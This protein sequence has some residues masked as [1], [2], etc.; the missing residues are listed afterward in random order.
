MLAIETSCDETA[1]ALAE[2]D[3]SSVI[4][5]DNE[6]SLKDSSAL[7]QNDS[8][9]KILAEKVAS[10][11]KVHRPYGGVVPNLAKREHLKN[12]PILLASLSDQLSVTSDQL[13]N[14]VDLIAVTV[15]P[16]LEPAL[17]TGINF[18]N[19]LGKELNVPVVGINH[20]EGHIFSNWLSPLRH[21]ERTP[22]SI[23]GKS[24]NLSNEISRH[25]SDSATQARNNDGKIE[26]P[27][28]V[29]LVSGGHT[30][31]LKMDSI[32]KWKKLGETRD[33]A[34]GE[35]FDKVAK[36][37]GL[38]YPG[39][40]EIEKLATSFIGCRTS[41]KRELIDFPRPM[42]H[43][44]NYDFSFSGLKTAVLYYLRNHNFLKSD[45][46]IL[47]NPTSLRSRISDRRRR[48]PALQDSKSDFIANICASFQQAAIDVLVKKTMRAVEEFDAKSVLL[49]GGVAANKALQEGLGF[50]VQGLG[51]QFFVPELKY[52]TDNAV[53]IA[54]A[55]CLGNH[56]PTEKALPNLSL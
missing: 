31:L 21:S 2:C 46:L 34:V 14:V 53:M 42:L 40:P 37:L 18:A 55:A 41:Y 52:N 16:G 15:G 22:D 1:L 36:M 39:G 44:K 6:G 5:S 30:I 35:A 50:G 8:G 47:G 33:D 29:L 17:W 48:C 51:R 3:G 10:Q 27:A 54:A 56:Y 26:F 12:L 23:R 19:D 11:I 7:P 9:F 4:L 32:K 13:H 49:C 28:I 45:F 43:S 24:K 25:E 38:P 20:L